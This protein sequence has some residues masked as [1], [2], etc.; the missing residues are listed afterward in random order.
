[1]QE[2]DDAQQEGGKRRLGVHPPEGCIEDAHQHRHE[3]VLEGTVE[4]V[5]QAVH[6][7]DSAPADLSE[8]KLEVLVLKQAV[9]IETFG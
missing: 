2:A 6:A 5:R 7:R 8:C 3:D 9:P 1:M 4:L